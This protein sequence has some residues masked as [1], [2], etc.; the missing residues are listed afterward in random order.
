MK[1]IP[2]VLLKKAGKRYFIDAMGAMAL[3]LFSSLIIGLIISQLARLPGLSLLQPI[4]AA[5]SAASPVT[6]C[7]IGV[8]IAWS[9]KAKSLVLFSNAAVGAVGYLAGGP[10]G[11]YV[12]AVIGTE[13]GGLVIGH[14]P[15]DI[16]LVPLS[17]IISGGLVGVWCGPTV[18]QATTYIGSIV[19]EAT[20]LAPISMGILVSVIMG[21]VLT[22]PISSA[23]LS[24]MLG[25]SGLAAGASTAGCCAQMIGFAVASFQD[26][27]INGLLAQGLGTSMLQMPNIMRRPQIWLAPILASA[28]T[29]PLATKVFAMSNTSYGAGMGTSGLVG[30]LG[31]FE[32]MGYSWDVL[33][34]V[35]LICF[36]LPA[37]FTLIFHRIFLKLGW[38]RPGDM[39]LKTLD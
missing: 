21:I 32:T 27:G 24:I 36:I 9:L 5:L 29:G 31:T 22:L 23:A 39:K 37:I 30:Q 8:A 7:A 38:V 4:G 6:G 25:L 12:A 3:G 18:Q 28:I 19:N 10:V 17:T 15:A 26:N 33:L 20:T 1:F 2:K 16:I 34:K 14:T 13:V 35:L 11:A